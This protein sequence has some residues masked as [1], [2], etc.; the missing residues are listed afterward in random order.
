[1]ALR[2]EEGAD[3]NAAE[4][5]KRRAINA[6][7]DLLLD[8]DDT[9]P[10]DRVARGGNITVRI[11]H[12]TNAPRDSSDDEEVI[13]PEEHLLTLDQELRWIPAN[14]KSTSPFRPIE[15]KEP[16]QRQI[17][18]QTTDVDRTVQWDWAGLRQSRIRISLGRN[19]RGLARSKSVE[20]M[21][22]D[23]A[24]MQSALKDCS[25]GELRAMIR[26]A[27]GHPLNSAER[28][29]LMR[30]RRKS[31]EP[32]KQDGPLLHIVNEGAFSPPR[33]LIY[34]EGH[35]CFDQPITKLT[36]R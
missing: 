30:A 1:M 33:A 23:R 25:A 14:P 19:K 4:Q 7:V 18:T 10:S 2:R 28:V 29:Q 21:A 32:R 36:R 9:R 5:W 15:F 34:W 11:T 13:F 31:S 27:A 22:I 24:D 26:S 3:R 20:E 8:P 17:R 6:L 16:S 35:F 12:P